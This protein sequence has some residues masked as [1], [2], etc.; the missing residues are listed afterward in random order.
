MCTAC[1]FPL[2]MGCSTVSAK[3][4]IA[5]EYTEAEDRALKEDFLLEE[6][7]NL[8]TIAEQSY[9]GEQYLEPEKLAAKWGPA[10]TVSDPLCQQFDPETSDPRDFDLRTL[11]HYR[12]HEPKSEDPFGDYTLVNE[13]IFMTRDKNRRLRGKKDYIEMAR[14]SNI[15]PNNRARAEA[16]L[17]LPASL[18]PIRGRVEPPD[19]AFTEA[20][21]K[22]VP[23]LDEQARDFLLNIEPISIPGEKN[24]IRVEEFA[25]MMIQIMFEESQGPLQITPK[26][27]KNW[28]KWSEGFKRKYGAKFMG[29]HLFASKLV[30]ALANGDTGRVLAT[31]HEREMEDWVLSQPVR[32]VLPHSLFRKAYQ[33]NNGDVYLA[34]VLI[35]S[36]CSRYRFWAERDQLE[37]SNRFG[38]FLNHLGDKLDLYGPYYHFFGTMIYAYESGGMLGKAAG[39]FEK[40][41][42]LFGSEGKEYQEAFVN[43]MGAKVGARLH[44]LLK[45]HAFDNWV[46]DPTLTSPERY[47]DR[48]EDFSARILEYWQRH[49][50]TDTSH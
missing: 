2:V 18:P 26:I 48:T 4:K 50:P 23:E 7:P 36:I 10:P 32:S 1:A 39:H 12:Q 46:S 31:G 43:V 11:V 40:L 17:R 14:F 6:I 3:R 38:L 28:F 19:R 5:S 25:Q 44:R 33:L 30:T 24:P 16:C 20:A 34:L 45:D 29:Y 35:E 15:N 22:K 41:N 49:H 9:P 37:F 21:L 13:F 47:L 42:Q 8:E 27:H